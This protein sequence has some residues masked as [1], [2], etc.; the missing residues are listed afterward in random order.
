MNTQPFFLAGEG[1]GETLEYFL[2]Y[3][4][5]YLPKLI[6]FKEKKKHFHLNL[7]AFSIVTMGM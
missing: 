4:E 2:K 6:I 5:K 7:A 3:I 1:G